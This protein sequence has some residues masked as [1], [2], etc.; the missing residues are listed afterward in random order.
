MRSGD[1]NERSEAL[2]LVGGH[3]RLLLQHRSAVALLVVGHVRLAVSDLLVTARRLE[4]LDASFLVSVL[5]RICEL[6]V[7]GNH[8]ALRLLGLLRRLVHGSA[9]LLVPRDQLCAQICTGLL[10]LLSKAVVH[11]TV[12]LLLNGCLVFIAGLGQQSFH[13]I[14]PAFFLKDPVV[15]TVVVIAHP[16][17][18]AFEET[19]EE[20]VVRLFFKLHVA[21]V[22]HVLRELFWVPAGQLLHRRLIFLFLYLV[23]LIVLGLASET[24]PWQLALQ[25]V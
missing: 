20:I 22:A 8:L 24:L 10:S 9:P 5:R 16:L 13:L 4:T 3:S 14:N 23:I 7:V 15:L 12:L 6:V 1:R 2:R 11:L 19:A 18:D 25:K 21:A 17:H